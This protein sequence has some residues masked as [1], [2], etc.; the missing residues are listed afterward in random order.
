M[1]E[2][3]IIPAPESAVH[4]WADA[5]TRAGPVTVSLR[6]AVRDT[7]PP[8]ISLVLSPGLETLERRSSGRDKQKATDRWCT[9]APKEIG[10]NVVVFQE[11]A[12]STY[13]PPLAR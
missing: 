7:R 6:L 3:A 11:L 13:F 8:I 5:S 10:I 4:A 2:M 1:Y 9:H 12:V